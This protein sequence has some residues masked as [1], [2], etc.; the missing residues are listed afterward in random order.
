ME[1]KIT[2]HKNFFK[3]VGSLN[4]ENMDV[5]NNTFNDVFDRVKNLTISIEEVETMDEFGISALTHLYNLSKI[6]NRSM[7]VIGDGNR[8]LYKHFEHHTTAA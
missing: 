5:F 3:I 8:E 1:L 2:N 6:G 7:S 4:K